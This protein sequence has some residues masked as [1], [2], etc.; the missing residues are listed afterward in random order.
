MDYKALL[1][2]INKYKWFIIIIPIITVVITRYM[3]K[4]LP[5]Q[6]VSTALIATGVADQSKQV[7]AVQS[8]D[9]FKTGQEFTN[10][11]EKIKLKKVVSMLSYSLIIHDLECPRG[12]RFK[13]YSKTLDSL[14]ADQKQEVLVQFK[15]KLAKRETLAPADDQMVKLYQIV[16]SMGY[17]DDYLN[18]SL[19]VTH[20][21][22]SDFISVT[23]TSNKPQLSAF[24][25]N[26]LCRQFIANYNEDIE[27]NQNSNLA[28]L[29]SLLKRKELVKDQKTDSLRKFIS[30][31]G[32]LN[33]DKQSETAYADLSAAHARKD[34]A[35]R[36]IQ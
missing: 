30:A 29:D 1:R 17:D 27:S 25:V 26:T 3:V 24:V 35:V 12:S 8:L 21:D 34:V 32:V 16:A 31:S 20:A 36:K 28:L 6:F 2:H 11:I 5:K 22:G 14:S 23:Y 15:E 9:F 19:Q 33:L 10:I 18:K 7:S 4:D 13:K